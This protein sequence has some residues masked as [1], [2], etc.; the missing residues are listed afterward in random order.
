MKR[1]S[2]V[3]LTGRAARYLQIL[4][5]FGHLDDEQVARVVLAVPGATGRRLPL[6]DLPDVR[7]AAA[8][9]LFDRSQGE[10]DGVLAEDWPLLFS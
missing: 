5:D 8:S 10:L 3:R 6:A 1:P 2:V 4:Q 7:R 9:L